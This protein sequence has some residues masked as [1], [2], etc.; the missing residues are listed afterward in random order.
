MAHKKKSAWR[1]H[2]LEGRGLPLNFIKA[3]F[4][5][6]NLD[7]KDFEKANQC[8]LPIYK[9]S[10]EVEVT[11]NEVVEKNFVRVKATDALLEANDIF[12]KGDYDSAMA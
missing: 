4:T 5:A 12:D 10:D 1:V 7:G 2:Q 8:I 6:K 11:T 9:G 3:H